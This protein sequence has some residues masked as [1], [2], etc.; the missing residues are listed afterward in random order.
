MGSSTRILNINEDFLLYVRFYRQ[1]VVDVEYLIYIDIDK[2]KKLAPDIETNKK[3]I[4]MMKD[5]KYDEEK[6]KDFLNYKKSI[7]SDSV[8]KFAP[9]RSKSTGSTRMQCS[10]RY[11]DFIKTILNN[12]DWIKFLPKGSDF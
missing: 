12:F 3:L 8:L 10:I 9:K 1:S 4:L 11:Y 5:S 2:W 7:E 6:W